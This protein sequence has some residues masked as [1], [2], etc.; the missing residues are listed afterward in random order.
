MLNKFYQASNQ[1]TKVRHFNSISIFL[2]TYVRFFLSSVSY[3]S[4][5]V[6]INVNVNVNVGGGEG[7][8]G[9]QTQGNLTF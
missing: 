3:I 6:P 8:G 1:W 5:N 2:I 9:W 7:G 4:V